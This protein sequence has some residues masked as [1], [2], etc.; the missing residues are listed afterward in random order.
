M[1]GNYNIPTLGKV[2]QTWILPLPP[3][4]S[5]SCNLGL[6][7]IIQASVWYLE[8]NVSNLSSINNDMRS[9]E[10][11]PVSCFVHFGHLMQRTDSLGEILMLEKI[12][13]RRGWQDEIVGWH[14]WLD[15]HEFMS[16][17]S[18]W[19]WWWTGKSGVL[20]SMGLQRVGHNQATEHSKSE[21]EATGL[22]IGIWGGEVHSYETEPWNCGVWYWP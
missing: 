5:N 3:H 4:I 14:H 13:G 22:L 18:S 9:L 10:N 11:Y 19:S 12:E 21:T 2:F 17:R 16:L 7:L 1:K 6:F 15:G 8:K 20:Q